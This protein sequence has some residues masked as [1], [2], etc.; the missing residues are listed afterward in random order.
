MKIVLSIL[1]WIVIILMIVFGVKSIIGSIATRNRKK[2][3]Q[4]KQEQQNNDDKKI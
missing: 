3:K 4:Q 2:T 1:I